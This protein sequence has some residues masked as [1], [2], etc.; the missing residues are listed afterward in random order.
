MQTSE[1]VD[2]VRSSCSAL[3]VSLPLI[4]PLYVENL[5]EYVCAFLGNHW[6]DSII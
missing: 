1:A 4:M 5:V 3:S 2:L 6:L